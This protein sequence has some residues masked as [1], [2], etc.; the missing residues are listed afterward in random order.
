MSVWAVIILVVLIWGYYKVRDWA[1]MHAQHRRVIASK[2]SCGRCHANK[3]KEREK[4]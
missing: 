1:G 2:C 4:H 3:M